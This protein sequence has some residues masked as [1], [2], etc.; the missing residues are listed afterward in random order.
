MHRKPFPL[1]LRMV[2]H[3]DVN[4]TEPS[5]HDPTPVSIWNATHPPPHVRLTNLV[6]ASAAW[7]IANGSVPVTWF[8]S[9]KILG[10]FDVAAQFIPQAARLDWDA[11]MAHLETS[12]GT[13]YQKQVLDYFTEI[14]QKRLVAA[15]LDAEEW[16]VSGSGLATSRFRFSAFEQ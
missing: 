10:F 2:D 16:T 5:R 15:G 11:L 12:D 4:A 14:R 1:H 13:E 8:S 7:C 3:Q 9:E 6:R